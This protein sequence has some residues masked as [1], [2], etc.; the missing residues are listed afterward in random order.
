MFLP[1]VVQ[2]DGEW[3]CGCFCHSFILRETPT[4]EWNL[5]HR[6][7]SSTDFCNASPSYSLQ[8]LMN[9][10]SVGPFHRVQF[11]IGAGYST[12]GALEQPLPVVL[13][14]A[15]PVNKPTLE[16]APFST[17][18]QLL[19]RTYS[20]T[21]FSWYHSLLWA[22]SPASPGTSIGPHPEGQPNSF[23]SLPWAAL[24]PPP[25]PSAVTLVSAKLFLSHSHSCHLW[26]QLLSHNNFF[27]SY[28][29][30]QKC[31][32]PLLVRGGS[33]WRWLV[34]VS[35]S[36]W[37]VSGNFSQKPLC[38]SSPPL[39]KPCHANPTQLLLSLG[40]Y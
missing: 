36:T 1:S 7:H 33:S 28:K 3:G 34:L 25:P 20:S 12:M 35:L 29:L 22:H 8:L 26:P 6:R 16:Q 14:R 10:S 19:P 37:E 5:S 32:L 2:G 4:P 31:H 9:Y 27:L 11:Y 30:C 24:A 21:Y 18:S 15:S 13:P 38:H 39:S 23:R 40:T 17:G